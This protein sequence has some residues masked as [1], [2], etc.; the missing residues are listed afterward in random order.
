MMALS[1]TLPLRKCPLNKFMPAVIGGIAALAALIWLRNTQ[2]QKSDDPPSLIVIHS[3]R[4]YDTPT[5]H[6]QSAPA[7]RLVVLPFR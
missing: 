6:R 7:S 4:R 5:L 1:S 3:P 2:K